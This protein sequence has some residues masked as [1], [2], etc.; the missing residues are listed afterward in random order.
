MTLLYDALGRPL[1]R[2]DYFDSEG[3]A[4]AHGVRRFGAED[5][6]AARRWEAAR[7]TR[8]NKGQWTGAYGYP[9][10]DDLSMDLETLR[11]RSSYEIQNNP[12]VRGV[13]DTWITDLVGPKGPQLNITTGRKRWG[14]QAEKLWGAWWK[15]P[16]VTGKL[17]GVDCLR[18]WLRSLWPGGEFLFQ[19]VTAQKETVLTGL[20]SSERKALE[21]VKMRVL[22]IAS[23]RL[24]TAGVPAQGTSQN[25]KIYLGVEVDENL[26]PIAY[27]IQDE[28]IGP[29]AA[30]A[31]NSKRVEAKD[32]I[33]GFVTEEPGQLRGIPLMASCLGTCADLRDYDRSVLRAAR[34]AARRDAV[35]Q[36]ADK[37]ASPI[38]LPA[39]GSM[40]IKE[41]AM[42]VVP[43]GWEMVGFNATQP[44]VMYVEFRKERLR[45]LGRPVSMPLMIVRLTSEDHNYSSAR[46]DDLVYR[47]SLDAWQGWLERICLD[48]LLMEV[49]RE[50]EL[51]GLGAMPDDVSWFWIWPERPMVD[52]A[53]ESAGERSQVEDGT[54]PY[55]LALRRRGL[56]LEQ[57]IA[58]RKADQAA[59]AAAG[60]PPL[61]DARKAAE[62]TVPEAPGDGGNGADGAGVEEVAP[63]RKKKGTLKNAA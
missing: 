52:A 45:D 29:Y 26:A 62:K 11:A 59:V 15:K 36:T 60:L 6:W 41:D 51:S 53:K 1:N 58:M 42:T 7:T 61:P 55:S 8:M 32:I 23:R 16:D 25:A 22:S 14:V 30:F 43:R 47:E 35:L 33:H 9:I 34:N 3:E 18:L 63:S 24:A 39:G 46:F 21:W 50:A 56:T 19:K 13:I 49:L 28:V 12:N 27:H 48:V 40:E 20:T 44:S 4:R 5:D 17:A 2:E 57:A 10:N 54:L 37:N 31:G 38:S